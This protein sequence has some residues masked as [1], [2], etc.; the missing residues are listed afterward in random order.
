MKEQDQERDHWDST[1]LIL[2]LMPPR[3]E[4]SVSTRI[5]LPLKRMTEAGPDS[6][7]FRVSLPRLLDVST[8]SRHTSSATSTTTAA[9]GSVSAMPCASMRRRRSW[10]RERPLRS[11]PCLNGGQPCGT[12]QPAARL[13][14]G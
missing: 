11:A 1:Y 12:G 10:R 2:S 14:L 5:A 7:A 13:E 8:T 6:S 3:M 9:S 4:F